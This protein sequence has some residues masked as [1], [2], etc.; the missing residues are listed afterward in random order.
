MNKNRLKIIIFCIC[1]SLLVILCSSVAF[2]SEIESNRGNIGT[3]PAKTKEAASF[4]TNITYDLEDDDPGKWRLSGDIPLD[5]YGNE[6]ETVK[7]RNATHIPG[8]L[9]IL[10]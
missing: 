1:V 6:A 8:F 4:D 2:A 10:Q 9:C 5:F 7:Q 3:T